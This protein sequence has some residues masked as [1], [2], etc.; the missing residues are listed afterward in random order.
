M[1]GRRNKDTPGAGSYRY[2]RA[3]PYYEIQSDRHLLKT[4]RD[5]IRHDEIGA[6]H[7]I[8]DACS[9]IICPFED[10]VETEVIYKIYIVPVLYKDNDI[11][12]IYFTPERDV[13]PFFISPGRKEFFYFFIQQVA[14]IPRVFPRQE[15]HLEVDQ[16][17]FVNRVLGAEVHKRGCILV[18]VTYYVIQRYQV[19]R[20]LQG[21]GRILIEQIGNDYRPHRAGSQIEIPPIRMRK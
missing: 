19:G 14:I 2:L 16:Q 18:D 15:S 5:E 20:R 3:V 12:F 13:L 21:I 1:V 8:P 7:H 17:L 11:R 9:I 6:D 4:R 10:V